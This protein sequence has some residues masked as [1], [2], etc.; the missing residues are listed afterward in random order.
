ME[1]A[2]WKES[3]VYE[4]YPRSFMDSNG[5]G[6]GD[7]RGIISQIDYL[8][9]LGIDTVWLAP[10]YQSPNI[11]YGYDITD[12]RSIQPEY[13]TMEDWQLL[14]N[15]LHRRGIRLLMD[16][17][18][19]H[20]SDEHPWFQNARSSRDS[21]FRDYYIWRPAQA[22]GG[23]PNNWTSFLGE[24]AW[25]LDETTGE[26]Y[27]HLYHAKQPDL[28]WD[29][30]ELRHEM[31]DM[32]CFWLD[33]GIDGFR[34]DSVNSLSKDQNFPDTDKDKIQDSG[35]DFTR[36]GPYIHEYLHE[37]HE[38]V[39]SR[40]NVFTAGETSKVTDSDVLKYTHPDRKE[41]SMVISPEASS[42]GDQP[43]DQWQNKAWSLADLRKIIWMCQKDIGDAG[44]WFGLYFSNHDQPRMVSTFGD[45]GTYRTE[46]AKMM[47]T[48][49]HTLRGTPFFL[50]GEELG[51]TN[52]PLLTSIKDFKEQQALHYYDV[53]VH[54]KG[55]DPET[56]LERIKA[57]SRDHARNPM[58]WNDTIQA[59]F[60]SGT[61]WMPVHPDYKEVNVLKERADPHS[62]LNYYKKLISLRKEH[63]IMVYGDFR[64][65]LE[66]HQQIFSYLRSMDGEN[67]LVLLNF[68]GEEA[69]YTMSDEEAGL[70]R[71]GNRLIGNY[72]EP[73]HAEDMVSGTLR[74]YEAVVYRCQG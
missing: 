35:E 58:Q 57:K 11:D 7:I 8:Q 59:G 28:N 32:M 27:L 60:T 53:M 6:I 14:L 9:E 52:H 25:T 47:A 2:N 46:S 69:S 4:I 51:M 50:Q 10:I 45:Q 29:N 63:P 21:R 72:P 19:N 26:Y 22:D 17:V 31:Y 42:L 64:F 40:Y 18:L 48:F 30:P 73:Q 56:I 1:K 38:Q 44:G 13:G 34:L 37:M 65:I 49:L 74:P 33:Q 71:G 23:P 24:P 41:L 12:Y 55:E 43:H 61:P 62:V 5:D 70:I 54:D 15:E 39:F 67:W 68:S 20:T 3:V 16:L 66:D 36:N